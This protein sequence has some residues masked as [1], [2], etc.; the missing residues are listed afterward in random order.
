MIVWHHTEY[1]ICEYR[2]LSIPG[3]AGNLLCDLR[4]VTL[5]LCASLSLSVQPPKA[6]RRSELIFVRC[7]V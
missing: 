6:V 2:L 5:P 1:G 7:G 4:H 3:S